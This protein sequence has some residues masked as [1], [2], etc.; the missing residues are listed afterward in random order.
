MIKR[1]DIL[2]KYGASGKDLK[3]LL[4]YTQNHFHHHGMKRM[5]DEKFAKVWMSYGGN[6]DS[7]REKIIEFNFPIEE[8]ISN[9]E[10][11]IKATE[12]GVLDSSYRD[13]KGLDLKS[14]SLD[15]VQTPGGKMPVMILRD[16][17]EFE[18]VV[19]CFSY[20]N[21]PGKVPKSMG[22]STYAGYNNW[23]RIRAYKE[24]WFSLNRD[25]NEVEWSKE[26]D[27]L[28]KNTT[29]FKD[30][31]I[32]LSNGPYSAVPANSLKLSEGMWSEFSLNI[33]K[34]HE[35]CHYFTKRVLGTMRNNII[36]EIFCDYV[37][38]VK[39]TGNFDLEWALRFLGLE[40][41]PKY[42]EGGRLQNYASVDSESSK[43]IIQD[44]VFDA[45][46]NI[47]SLDHSADPYKTIY[48]LSR[49]SLVEI[50]G[51]FERVER[52]FEE[53]KR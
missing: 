13:G 1:E 25:A 41:Y 18:K 23:D 14:I 46:T 3:E 40:N 37:G 2:K 7:L 22:A 43:Q 53:V 8:N 17:S 4:K 52:H 6:F 45:I 12:T 30:S 42:R 5:D 48:E 33:R 21:E 27:R 20:N 32:V 35:T 9:S 38:L 47:A 28:S 36:D 39:A 10:A 34:Y 29:L 50:A 16:R 49:F 51:D 11:Y 31:F 15:F 24:E 44:L 26:F 19:Q